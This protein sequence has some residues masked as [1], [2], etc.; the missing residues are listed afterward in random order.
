MLLF[1]M[2]GFPYFINKLPYA[3]RSRN[4]YRPERGKGSRPKGKH[5]GGA[6]YNVK[7]AVRQKHN[8]C[9]GDNTNT[10]EYGGYYKQYQKIMPILYLHPYPFTKVY[11]FFLD[12]FKN[13]LHKDLRNVI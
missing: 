3:E 9:C 4:T 5:G 10:K 7:L 2:R 6:G 11:C 8:K 13:F 1:F 12:F